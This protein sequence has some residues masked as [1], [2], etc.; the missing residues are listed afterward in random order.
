MKILLMDDD[1]VIQRLFGA[2]LEER[3]HSVVVAPT[4]EE[5]LTEI[6][7]GFSPEIAILDLINPGIGGEKTAEKIQQVNP[8]TKILLI[9][10]DHEELAEVGKRLNLKTLPKPFPFASLEKMIK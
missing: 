10:G 8:K 1:I 6:K 4:G 7:N 5:A 9:S 3:G 2:L